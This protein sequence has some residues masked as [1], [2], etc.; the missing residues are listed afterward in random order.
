MKSAQKI[1]ESLLAS[2]VI[3][4]MSEPVMFAEA[5]SAGITP[6]YAQ[7]Q[8][9]QTLAFTTSLN[10]PVNWQVNFVN[11]GSA[12]SGTIDSSGHYTAPA[13][14]PT[15]PAVTITAS[16]AGT[17]TQ[18]VTA[19]VTLLSQ[20]IAGKI[21]YVATNGLDTNAGTLAA[22]FATI[23]HAQNL[24]D[25]GDTILVRGGVYNALV[26]FK[27]SGTAAAPITY[28]NYPGES[29]IIDGTGLTIPNQQAGLFT[30]NSVSNVIITGFELRNYTTSKITEVPIGIFIT[31]AGDG[32][33]IVN[34]HITVIT[35][36]AATT[37]KACS[38]NALGFAVYASK[39]PAPVSNLV[40]S[41]NEVDHLLTGCS[42]SV[43]FNGNVDGFLATANNIHDNDNIGMDAIGFEKVS[44]KPAYDQARNGVIR[45]NVV[46]NITSYGN[47]DY[48]NQYAA[49]GLYVDGGTQIVIE[50]NRVSNADLGIE[51]A[52]EHLGKL[53]SYIIA[54]NNLVTGDPSNGISIGGYGPGR[55]GTQFCTI[56]NNT[57]YDNDTKNT[58]S[59]EFQIQ[60]HGANNVFANNVVYAL[61][62]RHVINNY[63][64]NTTAPTSLSNNL[65]FSPDGATTKFVWNAKTRTGFSAYKTASL[66]DANSLFADPQFSDAATGQF[67]L[68]TTSPALTLGAAGS[69]ALSGAADLSGVPVLNISPIAA[70]ALQN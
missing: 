56:I 6:G 41:G 29:P 8:P 43:T 59:G 45:G 57:L 50:Q 25:P 63:T 7:I 17:H 47:P 21:Y 66:Q 39:A 27:R 62:G 31:G 11:G 12:A 36:T 33:Q 28:A 3:L 18:T 5:P 35:T 52:S 65:Y 58:G 61:A 26:D 9:G 22:P 54:R 23:Q 67:F 55:G 1:T 19:T 60:Y 46:T 24:A 49:D 20:A 38:S 10:G 68:L 15:L 40:F 13:T 53:T 51:L 4:S 14:L 34:N 2:S 37:P 69:A 70:G 30:L 16:L 42:E 48:G 64:K 44:P 32:V